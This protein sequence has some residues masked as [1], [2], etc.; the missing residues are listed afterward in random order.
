VAQPPHTGPLDKDAQVDFMIRVECT[1][2]GYNLMFNS[3]RF[4]GDDT[5]MI[6][7]Q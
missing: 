3:E 6:D 2:C 4:Y 5:P 1:L 7:A